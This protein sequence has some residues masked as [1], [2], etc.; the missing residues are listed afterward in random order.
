MPWP[1]D[2]LMLVRHGETEWNRERRRQGQLD[3]PLTEAGMCHADTV[4]SYVVR[5][6]I[7]MIFT[8]PLGRAHQ[9]ALIVAARAD[10]PVHVLNDLAEVHHGTFAGLTNEE[11]EVAHPGEL[12]RRERTKYTWRFPEGESYADA[13]RRASAALQVVA[14]AGATA[15][16]LV[17]HEMIGRMLIRALL[18]RSPEEALTWS[19]THGSLI[20]VVPGDRKMRTIQP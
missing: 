18:D 11:I 6:A 9:T 15:P 10:R 2:R 12:G 14:D 17:S 1:F 13:D 7:D 5:S 4:A 19:L 16:L 20:E 3:S 8:S